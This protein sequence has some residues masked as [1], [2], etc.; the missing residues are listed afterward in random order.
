MLMVSL[1]AFWYSFFNSLWIIFLWKVSFRHFFAIRLSLG[2]GHSDPHPNVQQAAANTADPAVCCRRRRCALR[3]RVYLRGWVV[4]TAGPAKQRP[5]FQ[6]P[7]SHFKA[8]A[9]KCLTVDNQTVLIT[10]RSTRMSGGRQMGF[11]SSVHTEPATKLTPVSV[12]QWF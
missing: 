8:R 10:R 2:H 9:W 4:D 7:R 5:S 11:R 3:G 1:N 12:G 6:R